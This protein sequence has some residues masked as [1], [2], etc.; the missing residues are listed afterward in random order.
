MLAATYDQESIDKIGAHGIKADPDQARIW[1]ERAKQ[2]GVEGADVKLAALKRAWADHLAP[3]LAPTPPSPAAA[4]A[5]SEPTQLAEAEPN[6]AADAPPDDDGD[7]T[8]S[9]I[10]VVPVPPTSLPMPPTGKDAWVALVGYANVRVAPSSNAETIKIAE[11]GSKFRATGY[12][13]NWVQV[14]DPETAEVGWIYSRYVEA[15]PGQ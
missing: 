1:Y 12:K 3:A 14:T 8:V 7:V 13:G 5:P 9:G 11:K 15:T 10:G 2:L 6:A 4:A